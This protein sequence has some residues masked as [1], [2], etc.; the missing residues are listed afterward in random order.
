MVGYPSDSLVSC[1][2]LIGV[3]ALSNMWQANDVI[4]SKRLAAIM[5]VCCQWE[6]WLTLLQVWRVC[7]LGEWP[8]HPATSSYA[9]HRSEA[10]SLCLLHLHGNT[11]HL[12]QA[13]RPHQT[14]DH[15]DIIHGCSGRRHDGLL[16]PL[17]FLWDGES[18]QLAGTCRGSP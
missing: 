3:W 14:L 10:V 2:M 1:C 4:L 6:V 12:T 18:S 11:S 5:Q 8:Q 9:S 17:V 16:M 15:G 13:A 7:V